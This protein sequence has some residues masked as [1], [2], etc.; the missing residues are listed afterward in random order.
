MVDALAAQ[1]LLDSSSTARSSHSRVGAPASRG[2]RAGLGITDPDEARAS[3]IPVFYYLFD[4][5]HLDGEA[6][7]ELPLDVA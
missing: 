4:L 5:M 6:T 2:C 7:T 1:M 3:G